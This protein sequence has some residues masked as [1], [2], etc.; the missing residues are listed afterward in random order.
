[1]SRIGSLL[2][3]RGKTTISCTNHITVKREHGFFKGT[4]LRNGNYPVPG[5]FYGFMEN[6]SVVEPFALVEADYFWFCS[7]CGKKCYLVG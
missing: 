6:V 4:P 7:Q 1:M 3:I 5:R 2:Q